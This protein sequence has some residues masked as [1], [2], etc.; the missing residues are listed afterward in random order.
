MFPGHRYTEARRPLPH[1][2][3]GEAVHGRKLQGPF[4]NLENKLGVNNLPGV[5]II[6]PVTVTC[7]DQE[8]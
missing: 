4:R 6:T 3:P 1:T 5:S 2:Q 8:I 7:K